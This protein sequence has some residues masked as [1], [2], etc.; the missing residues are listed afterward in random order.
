MPEIDAEKNAT[1]VV[2]TLR[3]AG[4]VAYFAGGCVRDRLLGL[5]AK[6]YDVATDAPPDRVRQLFKKTQAVGA[7]FGVILVRLGGTMIEVATFRSDGA[8]EDGRRPESVTFSTAEQDAQ[9]RDFTINGLFFDPI[10]SKVIDY[11]GGQADLSAKVL[12]AIGD[13]TARLMEDHLRLLRAV[14]FAARFGLTI[15]PATAAAMNAASPLLPK[16]SAERIA[17]ELRRILTVPTHEAGYRLLWQHGLLRPILP[18]LAGDNTRLDEHHSLLLR[19]EPGEAVAF[20]I[21]CLAMLLDVRWQAG[22]ARDDLVSYLAP[23]EAAKLVALA[24][25]T[26]RLSNDDLETIADIARHVHGVLATPSP[27]DARLKRFLARPSADQARQLLDAIADVGT[28]TGRIEALQPR[29]EKLSLGEVAPPP[30]LTGDTLIRA[31]Y[32]PGVW[33]KHVLDAVYDAQLNGLLADPDAAIALA[34]QL[35]PSPPQNA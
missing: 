7:A 27:D 32:R 3:A 5:P 2:T 16:I 19:L 29:F 14:R 4:H 33:F 12:R 1:T 21:A 28:Q 26:F 10:E 15:E 34:R 13:P 30:L 23:A 17:D 6:D 22:E 24:R 18:R 9:R 35:A 25:Q 20:P 11:V 8:Y 31:G